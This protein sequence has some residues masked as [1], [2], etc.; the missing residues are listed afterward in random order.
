MPEV[1]RIFVEKK[2][3]FDVEARRTKSDLAENLG[4]KSIEDLRIVN[5][6]DISGLNPDEFDAAGG[7]IFSE[8]NA[9]RAS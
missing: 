7:T 3:G 8:P 1:I 5:R 2:P 4:M 9:R 6:Y